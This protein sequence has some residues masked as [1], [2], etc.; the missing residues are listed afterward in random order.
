M[1]FHPDGTLLVGSFGTDAVL[2]Y[3]ALTG[4]PLGQFITPGAGG[5][6]GTHNFAWMPVPA[7]PTAVV[8]MVAAVITGRRRR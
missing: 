7:A 2:R 4:Q 1:T 8:P 5:L 6:D 3:D